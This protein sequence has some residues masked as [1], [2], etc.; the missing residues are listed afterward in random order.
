MIHEK[1]LILILLLIILSSSCKAESL[2]S[3]GKIKSLENLYI[4]K[5]IY[6]KYNIKTD[7]EIPILSLLKLI[8]NGVADINL[9][10]KVN[11]LLEQ[12]KQEA[13]SMLDWTG[14]DWTGL[15]KEHFMN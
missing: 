7:S 9:R 8:H 4:S 6:K 2:T 3:D 5:K 12:T 14:L 10:N 15:D 13:S 1:S 11:I